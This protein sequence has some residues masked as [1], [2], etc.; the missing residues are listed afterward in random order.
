MTLDNKH[1]ISF[2]FGQKALDNALDTI[3]MQG[4][5]PVHPSPTGTDKPKHSREGERTSM[6]LSHVSQNS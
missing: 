3:C 6:Q 4:R 1:K 2:R 5:L